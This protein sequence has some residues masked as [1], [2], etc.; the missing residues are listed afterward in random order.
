MLMHT[1]THSHTPSPWNESMLRAGISGFLSLCRVC[2]CSSFFA[3]LLLYQPAA[4]QH[5]IRTLLLLLLQP[6]KETSSHPAANRVLDGSVQW[7]KGRLGM[8]AFEM[9]FAQKGVA[10]RRILAA[11]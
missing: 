3:L 10:F 8:N 4:G 5:C 1:H 7:F 9:L 2:T 6:A 11:F